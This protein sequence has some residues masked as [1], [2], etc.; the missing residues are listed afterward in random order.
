MMIHGH[1]N[2]VINNTISASP[3]G[4]PAWIS[5]AMLGIALVQLWATLG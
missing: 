3:A 4:P 1:Q 5:W 2:T